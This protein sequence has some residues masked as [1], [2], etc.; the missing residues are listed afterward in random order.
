M[1]ILL[2]DPPYK[3]LK[4]IGIDCAY[5]MGLAS[6]AG[7]LNAGGVDAAILTCDLLTDTAPGNILNMDAN[8]YARGQE[9]YKAAILDEG[10]PIWSRISEAIVAS[11][12]QAVGIMFLTPAKAV[13]E[14]IAAIIKAIDA[15]IPVIVGGHHPSFCYGDVLGNRHIDFAIRGEGEIPLWH[16]A[17]EIIR[18]SRNWPAVPG[19][20]YRDAVGELHST[21]DADLI[22]DLDSLPFAARDR[23]L[24]GDYQRYRT[25]YLYTARGCP[26]NCTFCADS[27]M[28]RHTVRRRS[29]AHVLAELRMLKAEYD[30][31]FVDFSDGTFTF[32]PKYLQHFCEAM[33]AEDL[34]LMWRCTARYDNLS[35]GMLRLMKKANCFG[36]YLGLES[37]SAAVLRGINKKTTPEQILETDK[38]IRDSGM[39][40]MAS[41]LMGLPDEKPEDVEQTLAFMRKMGCDLFDVNCYV[42]LPGTPLGGDMDPEAFK[43][44]D[45]LEAGFKSLTTNFSN[46]MSNRQFQEFLLEAYQIADDARS[47]FLNRMTTSL[48]K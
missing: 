7:Y 8:A 16:L 13:V 4:G 44:I 9:T 3:S 20:T 40:S 42:P 2:I 22:S 39:I 25:H 6:L 11:R 27:R 14:K 46:H 12:P 31:T 45:W 48:D 18:G 43:C 28:W 41:V 24:H 38:M 10:H 37:G 23:V 29:V 32:E 26:N 17:R 35:G 30:P 19:L 47:R 5:A 34:N 33:I 21:K 1:D 15:E 36:L